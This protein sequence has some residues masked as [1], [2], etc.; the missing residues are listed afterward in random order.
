MNITFQYSYSHDNAHG[1]LWLYPSASGPNSNIVCRY[2]ISRADR[3]IIFA[4]S[5]DSV[6]HAEA[7]AIANR[8]LSMDSTNAA[9]RG[10]RAFAYEQQGR[11]D[12][13]ATAWAAGS[14]A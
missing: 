8:L 10:L 9:A 1:L 7:L 13:A 6:K 4:F 11:W 3:G 2:N 14:A 12:E 5:G